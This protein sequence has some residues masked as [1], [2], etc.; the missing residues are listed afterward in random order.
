MNKNTS[1]LVTY[2]EMSLYVGANSNINNDIDDKGENNTI[3]D[4]TI[5]LWDINYLTVYQSFKL[6]LHIEKFCL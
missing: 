5:K 4:K 1:T 2:E 6:S 3:Y